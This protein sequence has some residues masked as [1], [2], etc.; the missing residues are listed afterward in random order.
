MKINKIEFSATQYIATET[1]KVQIYLHHTAGNASALGTA[2]WWSSNEDRIATSYVVAGNIKSTKETDGDIIE[3][4]DS[5]YWAYHLGLK[6]E[7]FTANKVPYQSLDKISIGI[8]VCNWGQLTKQ[9]DGT[10]LNYVNKAVDKS[11]VIE[12]KF[13]KYQYWHSYTDKQI[14]AL[15]ELL[16]MLCEK[17]GI[18]KVYNEDIWGVT[19]RALK[20]ENGIFTH[21]SVRTDKC[22]MY[23]HPQLIE[24]L[25]SL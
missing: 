7:V 17:H 23:P 16:L 21:N 13:K 8:E 22:D 9:K 6:Q 2:N 14:A 20:G 18:S 4:F 10:F 5:K 25:K 24:M 15:K 12:C 3:C 19:T 11:E 1:K